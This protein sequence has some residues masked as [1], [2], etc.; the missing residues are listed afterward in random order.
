[1]SDDAEEL[2]VMRPSKYA[3]DEEWARGVT[4]DLWELEER[5]R[6]AE[7]AL[8]V[9]AAALKVYQEEMKQF[10]EWLNGE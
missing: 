5:V 1:M 2:M 7:H 6:P 3:T 9:M 8:G 4:E 10:K